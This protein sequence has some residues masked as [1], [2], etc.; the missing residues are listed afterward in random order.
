[1]C[2]ETYY[3]FCSF[4]YDLG[5]LDLILNFPGYHRWKFTDVLRN[6]LKIVVSLFWVIILPLFYVNSFRGAPAGLKQLLSF[7]KQ[8]KGIPPLYMLAVALYLL[9][10]LLAA[11]LFL[12]PMLRR[13]IENSDWH[14]VR[15]FLWWSQVLLFTYIFN[16]FSSWL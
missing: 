3:H 10:N 5:I 16:Y 9:P 6:I 12:F 14:I 11:V 4:L 7:F 2:L 1:M 8:I 15:L 13:W